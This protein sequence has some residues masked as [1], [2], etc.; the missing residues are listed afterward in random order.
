MEN[1]ILGG[2]GS[3]SLFGSNGNEMILDPTGNDWI[4]SGAGNDTWMTSRIWATR[5]ACSTWPAWA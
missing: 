3:N 5:T 2:Q 1:K 4:D